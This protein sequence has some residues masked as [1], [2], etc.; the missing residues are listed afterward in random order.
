MSFEAALRMVRGDLAG[1]ESS[2]EAGLRSFPA[3]LPGGAAVHITIGILRL[4]RK[5]FAQAAACV[6]VVGSLERGEEGFAEA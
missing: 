4:R 2:F 6:L 5:E 1:E 3:V